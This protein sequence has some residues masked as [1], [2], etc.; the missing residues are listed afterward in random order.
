MNTDES[1][2][3]RERFVSSTAAE[4]AYE[5]LRFQGYCVVDSGL[6]DSEIHRLRLAF[7]EGH[8]TY[9]QRY[10]AR[11]DLEALGENHTIRVLPAVAPVF[12][13]LIEN[14]PLRALLDLIFGGSVI[15]NQVNGLFN[16]PSGATFSQRRWHR[17]LPYQHYVASRPLAVNAL[18]CLDDFTLENGATEVAPGT[19]KEEKFPSEAA[20]SEI[21]RT[22]EASAGC[23]LVLDAMTFH[24]AGTNT[25]DKPRRAVNHVYAIPPFRQQIALEIALDGSLAVPENM[26]QLLGFG[27]LEPRTVEEWLETRQAKMGE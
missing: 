21:A 27:R 22:I 9:I 1:Y 23:F 4:E 5:L 11:F 26:R 6:G 17:D 20:L 2:G 25:T 12:L 18:F 7:D 13:T 16:P 14:P 19:H 10:G 8:K 24:T 15:L 3:I